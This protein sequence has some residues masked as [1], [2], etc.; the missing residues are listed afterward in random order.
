MRNSI[1]ITIVL[2]IIASF[3]FVGC[4]DDAILTEVPQTDLD[5]KVEQVCEFVIN[6]DTLGNKF[7]FLETFDRND[8]TVKILYSKSF[9]T[10]LYAKIQIDGL[11]NYYEDDL[12][13][14]VYFCDTTYSPHVDGYMVGIDIVSIRNL[15]AE[16]AR[17]V[18][19]NYEKVLDFVLSFSRSYVYWEPCIEKLFDSTDCLV[20]YQSKGPE[21]DSALYASDFFWALLEEH[22]VDTS[23]FP[24]TDAS[25]SSFLILRK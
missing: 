3:A 24:Y 10:S 13:D 20:L 1:I 5:R 4:G 22:K 14:S 6:L 21:Y 9:K 19:E 15:T 16:E 7:Y 12:G 23:K 2:A 25:P 18:D 11:N 8:T 17:Q